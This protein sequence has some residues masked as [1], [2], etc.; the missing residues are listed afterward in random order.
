MWHPWRAFREREHLTLSWHDSDDLL[1]C[2]EHST[3]DV[4][5]TTGML[6]SE[7]RSTITHELIHDERGPAPA[8]FEEQE[9]ATVRRL[10]AERLIPF[11]ELV[12]A[13]FWCYGEWE[14]ADHFHVDVDVVVDR[15]RSLSPSE[16]AFINAEMDRREKSF[17]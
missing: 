2:I 9:E 10:T 17:G 11:A 13:M 16:T 4:S 5:L 6:Q 14:L 12:D 1:G 7:R 3:G 8:G 15:L